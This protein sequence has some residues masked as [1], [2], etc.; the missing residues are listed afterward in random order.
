MEEALK[1]VLVTEKAHNDALDIYE[2]LLM[3]EWPAKINQCKT[4]KDCDTLRY[5]D[6]RKIYMCT[7]K[8]E[9]TRRLMAKYKDL[10]GEWPKQ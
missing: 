6:W 8:A 3:K 1:T 2:D 7:A 10:G 9:I 5:G 4:V